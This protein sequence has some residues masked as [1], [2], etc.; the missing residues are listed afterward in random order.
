MAPSKIISFTDDNCFNA[1]FT[2]YSIRSIV[3]QPAPRCHLPFAVM[4]ESRHPVLACIFPSISRVSLRSALPVIW[5]KVS[6]P[7]FSTSAIFRITTLETLARSGIQIG[8]A[9]A[10][11]ASQAVFAGRI[12]V[13]MR[14]APIR[15]CATASAPSSA[16]SF[17]VCEVL[18]QEETGVAIPSTLDVRGAS[19]SI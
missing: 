4:H 5:I 2:G 15:A 12:R 11:A 18:T 9:S 13:E 14:P 1:I 7:D 19:C 10:S 3:T 16:T 6:S 17:A 8:S